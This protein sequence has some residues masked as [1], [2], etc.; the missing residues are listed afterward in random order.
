MNG[1]RPIEGKLW[2]EILWSVIPFGL[3]MVMFVW[4]A[5]IFFD[6]YNPPDD[7]LE[8]SIVGRQWMWKVQHPTGQSEINE[9][10]V[11]LGQPVKLLMTSEDVIHDCF[12][13]RRFASNKTCSPAVIRAYGSR[14]PRPGSIN[15]FAPNIAARS[16]RG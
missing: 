11:P 12:V 1:P 9:L 7:A 15:Y 13:C 3:T 6:I 2:L 4:G 5:V 8:I 10:H 16:I 14:R